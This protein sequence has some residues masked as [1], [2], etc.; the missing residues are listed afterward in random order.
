MGFLGAHR[1]RAEP[2]PTCDS[3]YMSIHRKSGLVK[4]ELK[5]NGGRFWANAFEL[6]QPV[7]SFAH[8]QVFQKGYV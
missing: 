1:L 4:R 3:M 6:Y 7:S 2:N 8:R 5:Y